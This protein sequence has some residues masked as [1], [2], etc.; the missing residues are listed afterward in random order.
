M[1]RLILVFSIGSLMALLPLSLNPRSPTPIRI[2]TACA[3]AEECIGAEDYICSMSD[4]D[5]VGAVC[6]RGCEPS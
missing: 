4:R 1:K 3:Q 2:S 5:Y 6:I